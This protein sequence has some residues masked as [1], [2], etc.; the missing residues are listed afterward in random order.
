MLI[1]LQVGIFQVGSFFIG[2]QDGSAAPSGTGFY[3]LNILQTGY[4]TFN[5]DNGFLLH[6]FRSTLNHG[7]HLD[8]EHWQ[9]RIG[10]YLHFQLFPGDITQ[11]G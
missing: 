10:E 3:L 11:Q 6:V 1:Q 5:R 8:K 9:F 2:D 4:Y 7:I